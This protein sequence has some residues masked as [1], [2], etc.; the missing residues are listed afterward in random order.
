MVTIRELVYQ[1]ILDRKKPYRISL[2][3][4][5]NEIKLP[6]SLS[7]NTIAALLVCLLYPH[8]API[9]KLIP[10]KYMDS[11]VL[12]LV[13]DNGSSLFRVR[14]KPGH[15]KIS[16]Q[17]ENQGV[18]SELAHNMRQT[19]KE[20]QT[21]LKLPS[22]ELF[23]AV[24][25][26]RVG[27]SPE[28]ATPK[29]LSDILKYPELC[30]KAGISKKTGSL[31]MLTNYLEEYEKSL[32]LEK[33][34]EEIT[35][36]SQELASIRPISD[37]SLRELR[38]ERKNLLDSVEMLPKPFEFNHQEERFLER[39]EGRQD[40]L[41][42]KIETL[43]NQIPQ[44]VTELGAVDYPQK[45]REFWI[46]LLITAVSVYFA[47]VEGPPEVILGTILG[48]GIVSFTCIRFISQR[49]K[50]SKKKLAKEIAVRKSDRARN[51]LEQH[52]DTFH[53]LLRRG[54]AATLAELYG[55]RDEIQELQAKINEMALLIDAKEKKLNHKTPHLLKLEQRMEFLNKRQ[56]RLEQTLPR[57]EL[58]MCLTKEGVNPKA[59]LSV[60]RSTAGLT[61]NPLVLLAQREGVIPDKQQIS[62]S[63][64]APIAMLIGAVFPDAKDAK[65]K[66]EGDGVLTLYSKGEKKS[67]EELDKKT[68]WEFEK[69]ICLSIFV[70]WQKKQHQQ[71][72]KI[73][74]FLPL[75]IPWKDSDKATEKC[76][77]TLLDNFAKTHQTVIFI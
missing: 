44:I 39:A 40:N 11:L 22:I 20:L 30:K 6:K 46:G 15:K 34:E 60:F 54:N 43:E 77:R 31:S 5:L 49:E 25:F 72:K 63:E 66:L 12:G 8:S 21:L 18:Y 27:S 56:S 14:F 69:T 29:Q 65:L 17:S 32:E 16:L 42:L 61:K 70:A 4:G 62:S 74:Y 7:P 76:W 13:F 67:F 36:S 37:N 57:Y 10:S 28:A 55:V 41:S 73:G 23:Q 38:R 9:N 19:E 64:L 51:D 26:L 2:T 3:P 68:R 1:G 24:L 50:I 71:G 47:L 35:T 75:L 48:L 45:A 33:I 59:V 58:E 52:N 53:E